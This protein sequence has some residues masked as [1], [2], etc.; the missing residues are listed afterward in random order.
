MSENKMFQV[1]FFLNYTIFFNN[2]NMFIFVFTEEVSFLVLVKETQIIDVSLL[3]GDK[4]SGY[5]VAI[6]GIENGIQID[7]DR[8]TETLFWVEGKEEDSENVCQD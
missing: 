8:K 1:F 5:M 4:T 6:V 7:F 3:P 2:I